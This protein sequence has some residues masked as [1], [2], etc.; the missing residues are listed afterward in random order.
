MNN[1]YQVLTYGI[2]IKNK[3]IKILF[4]FV[5]LRIYFYKPNLTGENQFI[6]TF[7]KKFTIIIIIKLLGNLSSIEKILNK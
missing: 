4:L 6:K 3:K 1:I 2:K 5:E 7:S